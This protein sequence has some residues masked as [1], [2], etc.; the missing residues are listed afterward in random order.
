MTHGRTAYITGFGAFLPGDPVGN[1]A[2]EDVL[3]RIG[4]KPSR[5]R[6]RVLERNGIRTRHYALD[7][8][9][10]R[11]HTNYEMAALAVRAALVE[12][13]LDPGRVDHLACATTLS[14][15]LVPG[16]ASLVQGEARIPPCDI[17]SLH[18]V[19]ASGVAALKSAFA[20]VSAGLA[21]TAVA[22]ASEFAS[23]HLRASVLEASG[24]ANAR[25]DLPFDA[26][27]LRFMLSDGAGAAVVRDRP[28][29]RGLSL[30]IE[31]I[32]V[33]SHADTRETC[34]YAGATKPDG[35]GFSRL[36][37]DEASYDRS[38]DAG[39]FVLR[40]DMSLLPAIV[41]LGIAHYLRLIERGQVVDAP[42][43]F[44]CHYSATHFRAEVLTRLA[45]LGVSLP[46][47]RWFS[48]LESRGNTGSAS[49]FLLLGDLVASGR[50]AVG[51]R[52]LAMIP[53]SGR[54]ITCYL[55]FTVV[56]P[57]DRGA[58]SPPAGSAVARPPSDDRPALASELRRRLAIAWI[59]FAEAVRLVPIV[60][61]I[62]SGRASLDDYRALLL[63]LRQQVVEGSRWIA[64]AA[65]NLGGA[66]L[67][68]RSLFIRHAAEEHRDF[69]MLERDYAAVGGDPARMRA[70]RKNA[71]SEALSA[72]MFQ[73][74]SRED[75]F[76]LAGAMAIIE[77]LGTRL[78]QGWGDALCRNLGL[79]REQVSF[80]LYHGE[81]DA[82]H[83]DGLDQALDLLPL[84]PA[85]VDG[86][87]RTAEV[88][89]R[90]YRLQ[91]EEI[92]H[93]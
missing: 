24:L 30:R 86:I 34:M 87:V 55:A 41:P 47:E 26:E 39:M 89:A 76:E 91:L 51:Q 69:L 3:G 71:G 1:D 64:R 49:L 27:F 16:F 22:C 21:D 65:S 79:A 61:R 80:L 5:H 38:A 11:T 52:V 9:G 8:D 78:A 18:G 19:C 70:Q 82:R 63:D 88:T 75:P 48:N 58:A 36:W 25:G 50:L 31:W 56:G 13:G 62:E 42:D 32:D 77:G 15:V 2:I 60:A 40:Q 54:F 45:E 53:E 35:Q 72:F 10:K 7:R 28:A 6:R 37:A 73:A 43:W 84:T 44:V 33:R 85:L 74:A 81:H 4:G 20:Q 92:A 66:H 17:A 59:D 68:L 12:A 83:L 90:L 57:D 93:D 67:E 23:R 29:A 46:E 14:D